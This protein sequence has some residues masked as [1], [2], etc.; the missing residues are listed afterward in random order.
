MCYIKTS[1]I[2]KFDSS[3]SNAE[4]IK[5]Y[6]VKINNEILYRDTLNFTE[7]FKNTSES[8]DLLNLVYAKFHLKDN[9]DYYKFKLAMLRKIRENPQPYTREMEN[10]ILLMPIKNHPNEKREIYELANIFYQQ[11]NQDITK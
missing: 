1:K 2:K 8:Q 10:I 7:Y 6:Q 11:K 9:R 4:F 5:S 3:V